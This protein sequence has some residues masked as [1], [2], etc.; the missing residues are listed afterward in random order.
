LTAVDAK[1]DH[2]L[3]SSSVEHAEWAEVYE[4]DDLMLTNGLAEPGERV[5]HLILVSLQGDVQ[6]DDA[7]M[8]TNGP[9]SDRYVVA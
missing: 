2:P 9:E 7:T 1:H 5:S 3:S 6:P 4:D 8:L